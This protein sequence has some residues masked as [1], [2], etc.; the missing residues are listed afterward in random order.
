MSEITI[1]LDEM[2]RFLGTDVLEGRNKF[3]ELALKEYPIFKEDYRP[4]LNNKII[5]RFYNREIGFETIDQFILNIK[6]TLNEEMPF[7]NQL[8]ESTEIKFDPMI[9]MKLNEQSNGESNSETESI[10]NT[11]NNA[12]NDT[13]SKSR[14][15]NSEMPNVM[16]ANRGDYASTGA[17]TFNNTHINTDTKA[18]TQDKSNF[19]VNSKN[20]REVTAATQSGSRL[21]MEYRN[22]MLNVDMMVLDSLEICFMQVW[23]IGDDY[24]SIVR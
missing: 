19:G 13:E 4:N 10:A 14:A 18:E 23:S 17:D 16:L 3:I 22:T 2:F 24:T 9:S 21:L 20:I 12:V 15:V 11:I 7:Y 6:R 1:R 8:Y 5:T